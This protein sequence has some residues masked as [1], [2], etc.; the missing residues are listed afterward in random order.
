ME[1]SYKGCCLII[2][3]TITAE[4]EP[5][6][7]CDCCGKHVSEIEAYKGTDIDYKNTYLIKTFRPCGYDNEDDEPWYGSSWEC[8]SCVVLSDDKYLKKRFSENHTEKD[9]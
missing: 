5:D 2:N 9:G 1:I 8:M 7:K 6:L 3:G 4:D